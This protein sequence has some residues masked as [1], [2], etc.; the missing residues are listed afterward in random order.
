MTFDFNNLG[1]SLM[2]NATEYMKKGVS[3]YAPT[4][5]AIAGANSFLSTIKDGWDW[6]NK[7]DGTGTSN[8]FNLLGYGGGIYNGYNQQKAAKKA[9]KLQQE[10]FDFNKML[11]QRQIDKEN[12]S[13]KNLDSAWAKSN[14]NK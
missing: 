8:G 7:T 12:Q 13:Q 5:G 14:Y 10:A 2:K 6:L 3:T 9:M 1:Q 4:T 11:A